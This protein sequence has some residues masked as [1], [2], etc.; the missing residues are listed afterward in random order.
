VVIPK[1][2][3]PD[4]I[5]ENWATLDFTLTAEELVAIDLLDT[6]VRQGGDP[7]VVGS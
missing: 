4:R 3:T 2:V 6:G 1:S 7:A 5:R